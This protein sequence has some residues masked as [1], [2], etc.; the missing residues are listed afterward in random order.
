MHLDTSKTIYTKIAF[1][2]D[3]YLFNTEEE[4]V[5]F[6][7]KQSNQ[8]IKDELY[9]MISE[10]RSKYTT[11]LSGTTIVAHMIKNAGRYIGLLN[12]A[13]KINND[14]GSNQDGR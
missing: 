12:E 8:K 11:E 4:A 9:A 6:K 13:R 5:E 1:V 2:Y 3:G 10:C 14:L 7:I